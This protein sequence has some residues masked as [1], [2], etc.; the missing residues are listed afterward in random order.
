[1]MRLDFR[2]HF[3]PHQTDVLRPPGPA[4]PP[5]SLLHRLD[6]L[7]HQAVRVLGLQLLVAQE[8]ERQLA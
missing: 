5:Y 6:E 4:P 2:A 7:A 1:M 8:V 3:Y